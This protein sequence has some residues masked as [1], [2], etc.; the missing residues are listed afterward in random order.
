M[1]L[2]MDAAKSSGA[3]LPAACAAQR[4]LKSNL[5]SNGDLDLSVINALCR[6]RQAQPQVSALRY[7]ARTCGSGEEPNCQKPTRRCH[8]LETRL[9][10]LKLFKLD[11][12]NTKPGGT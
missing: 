10:T 2:V 3:Y 4:V 7:K 11:G 6:R 5:A 8:S 1:D 12:T 9:N